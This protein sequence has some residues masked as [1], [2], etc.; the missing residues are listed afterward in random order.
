MEIYE[1]V[2]KDEPKGLKVDKKF[3]KRLNKSLGRYEPDTEYE[4]KCDEKGKTWK[5]AERKKK[6]VWEVNIGDGAQMTCGRQIEAE[7]LSYVVQI[8]A[9]LKR[10][11]GKLDERE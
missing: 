1:D 11:E 4:C 6:F 9:R 7:L 2:L 10:I 3:D 8:N 5:G